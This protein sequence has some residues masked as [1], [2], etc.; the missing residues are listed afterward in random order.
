MLIAE[1]R[2]ALVRRRL[3]DSNFYQ[4]ELSDP[5]NLVDPLGL[6]ADNP[7][8]Q[9]ATPVS[10][11]TR[12]GSHAVP[13]GTLSWALGE[14]GDTA[15]F[16]MNFTPDKGKCAC[17]DITFVQVVKSTQGT[18]NNQVTTFPGKPGDKD[19]EDY[20]KQFLTKDGWMVDHLKQSGI[21][22]Y[23]VKRDHDNTKWIDLPG[24]GTLGNGPAGVDATM[25][26][27]PGFASTQVRAGKG[28][29][30]ATWEVFAICISTGKVL[31]GVTWGTSV[32]DKA[33]SPFLLHGG[34]DADFLADPTQEWKD[35]VAQWNTVANQGHGYF[36]FNP[37]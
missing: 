13:G 2:K 24:V 5:I 1:E 22:F 29:A 8:T 16:V 4:F 26:D 32:E 11:N 25:S 30:N 27:L 37:K 19:N 21:P 34:G 12:K 10:V 36:P 28:D 17:T 33:G 20:Y 15:G 3:D 14:K 31:G 9:P 35:A 23:G 18:G 7:T 6:A